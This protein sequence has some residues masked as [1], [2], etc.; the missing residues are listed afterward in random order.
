M[1]LDGVGI[2]PFN[3]LPETEAVAALLACCSAPAL[4]RAV[5]AGRPYANV[6]DLLETADA[7]LAELPESEIDRALD[8]HPRIGDRP[9]TA[10]SA[11]EQATVASAAD[12][13]RAALAEGNRSYEERFGHIYLVCATGKSGAELLELLYARLGNDPQTERRVMRTELAKIN[14][15]RLRRMLGATG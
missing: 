12:S 14:R 8:G 13:I 4:A 15:I 1:T 11:R 6:E 10:S 3:A 9:D 2:A 5:A 7:V